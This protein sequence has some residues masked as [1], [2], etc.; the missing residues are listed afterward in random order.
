MLHSDGLVTWYKIK[1][2]L[3][4]VLH[5]FQTE[6]GLENG[7]MVLCLFTAISICLWTFGFDILVGILRGLFCYV[8]TILCKYVLFRIRISKIWTFGV[9]YLYILTYN[10]LIW[11]V[12]TFLIL[13]VMTWTSKFK[14]LIDLMRYFLFLK[15]L[16]TWIHGHL[17]S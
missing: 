14:R 11:L 6:I 17:N 4:L 10:N 2:I 12:C 16:R 15:G 1:L 7:G 8:W 5:E 13:G 3:I 9:L